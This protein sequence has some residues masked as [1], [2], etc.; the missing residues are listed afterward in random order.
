MNHGRV[1]A[2]LRE[3]ADEV[4]R[5]PHSAHEPGETRKRRKAREREPYKPVHPPSETDVA[6]AR[7]ALQR[8]GAV[9]VGAKR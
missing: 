5:S 2:L 6:A 8:A 3:L 1:A 7:R 9:V 4:E